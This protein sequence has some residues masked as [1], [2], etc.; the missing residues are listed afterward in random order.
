M[1]ETDEQFVE[2]MAG[3]GEIFGF[4]GDDI[5]RLHALA[6]RGAAAADRIEQ[7]EAALR[8]FAGYTNSEEYIK[9]GPDDGWCAAISYRVKHYREARAVLE[10][11]T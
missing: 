11:R 3:Y 6:R 7:L 4:D 10:E 1:I 9:S 8:P 2:R 5:E